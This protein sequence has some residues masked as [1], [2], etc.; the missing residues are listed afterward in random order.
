MTFGLVTAEAMA[1]GT[2]A[3]V[4]KNTAG[5]EII[6]SETGYTI[7]CIDEISALV[8]KCRENAEFY[9][10]ACRKRIVENF[11]SVRQYSK[12]VTLYNELL[13]GK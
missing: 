12:Y 3:I 2:P 6:D 13:Q 8:R 4:F 10:L 1:C 5:E 9:K 11:D 7:E